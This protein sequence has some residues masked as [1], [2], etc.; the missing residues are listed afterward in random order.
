MDALFEAYL[1]AL[2]RRRRSP[3]TLTA[4][5]HV[6]R[7]LD[8]RLRAQGIAATEFDLLACERYF[9]DLLDGHAVVTVRR[10]VATVRA[11][12]RYGIRH[13]LVSVDRRPVA[14]PARPGAGDLQQRAA[15]RD[16]RRRPQ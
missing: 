6:L 10:H 14:E 3:L 15:A 5:E 12:Y 2:R 7:R 9:S 11:A 8:A 4:N 16:P 1:D 13:G